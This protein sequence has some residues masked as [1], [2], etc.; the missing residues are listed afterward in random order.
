MLPQRCLHSNYTHYFLFCDWAWK[1][2]IIQFILSVK[3]NAPQI[4][5]FDGQ[6]WKHDST[7]IVVTAI[8]KCLSKKYF[9]FYGPAWKCF[10]V[11]IISHKR[12]T[13]TFV[14]LSGLKTLFHGDYWLQQY[15]LVAQEPHT[16]WKY[17][18]L[19]LPGFKTFCSLFY[20]AYQFD[21]QA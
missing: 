18:F 21:D 5:L 19:S 20:Q 9:L 11:Y 3:L 2:N 7:Q 14:W 13:N 1:E 15:I 6:A 8:I 12:T 17:F 4:F 10:V 16:R